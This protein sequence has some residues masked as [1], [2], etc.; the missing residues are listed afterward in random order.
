[1]RIEIGGAA[2]LRDRS[3]GFDGQ[4]CVRDIVVI[5][6]ESGTMVPGAQPVT[7]RYE[8][9][10]R[11]ARSGCKRTLDRG[12]DV[13]YNIA[14]GQRA[15]KVMDRIARWLPPARHARTRYQHRA[16]HAGTGCETDTRSVVHAVIF[17][18]IGIPRAGAAADR[19]SIA[20]PGHACPEA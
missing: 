5:R 16:R 4:A 14:T 15:R 9:C 7:F 19:V 3:S 20:A 18:G 10:T 8:D 6:V 2:E 13:R 1:M 11:K 12:Q 17:S